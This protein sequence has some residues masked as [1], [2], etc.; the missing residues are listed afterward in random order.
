MTIPS[1]IEHLIVSVRGDGSDAREN[2]NPTGL[3]LD[4]NLVASFAKPHRKPI[5]RW[6]SIANVR[7]VDR[8][9]LD[10]AAIP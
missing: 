10:H 1:A 7:E 3:V 2:N 6:P 5:N 8:L 4:P 9:R